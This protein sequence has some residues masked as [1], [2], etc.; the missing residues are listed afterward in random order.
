MTRTTIRASQCNHILTYH[1]DKH[2]ILPLVRLDRSTPLCPECVRYGVEIID[3][4]QNILAGLYGTGD[5]D[6]ESA[7]ADS[8]CEMNEVGLHTYALPGFG[9]NGTCTLAFRNGPPPGT[10]GVSQEQLYEQQQQPQQRYEQAQ[11]QTTNQ[12]LAASNQQ[13]PQQQQDYLA[14]IL[15]TYKQHHLDTYYPY[16]DAHTQ[17]PPNF[18]QYHQQQLNTTSSS[19]SSYPP[20]FQPAPPTNLLSHLT[21]HPPNTTSS[22]FN[23][24][25]P[26]APDMPTDTYF[27]TIRNDPAQEAYLRAGNNFFLQLQGQLQTQLQQQQQQQQQLQSQHVQG[28][29]QQRPF[30]HQDWVNCVKMRMCETGVTSYKAAERELWETVERVTSCLNA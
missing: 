21:L 2:F 23:P 29:G 7:V 22:H 3:P 5:I 8:G 15:S 10:F 11:G 25:A 18:P 12:P 28:Q 6:M 20:T 16:A 24:F 27:S 13:Q 14:S 26:P 19:S 30:L 4:S 1:T 17:A 9:L